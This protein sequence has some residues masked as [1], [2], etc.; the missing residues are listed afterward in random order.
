[1]TEATILVEVSS[2]LD[3]ALR[4]EQCLDHILFLTDSACHTSPT[5]LNLEQA[6]IWAACGFANNRQARS[7]AA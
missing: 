1:M 6:H 5:A 2:N 7:I 3:I 4:V